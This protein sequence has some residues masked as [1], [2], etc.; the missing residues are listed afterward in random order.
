MLFF[1]QKI[2]FVENLIKMKRIFIAIMLVSVFLTSCKENGKSNETKEN[3]ANESKVELQE[4]E[5]KETN[6]AICLLEKLSIRETPDAKGKWVTSM[7]LGEKITLLGEETTDDKTKKLYYKVKLTDGKEGW[8]R[9]SFLAVNG[10][11]GTFL[12]GATVYKRPDLLT[13]T[14]KKYSVMD[15]IGTLE[16]QGEWIKVKGKRTD[17]EY[18]EEGWIKSSNISNNTVDIATAKY[19]FLANQAPTITERI[20]ALQEI[21]DNSDLSSSV[22]I[23]KIKSKIE[24]YKS[25]NTLVDLQEAKAENEDSK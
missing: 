21:I 17:G 22:F 16:N 25:K 24:D 7:S 13:K 3:I 11:V 9:A 23:E 4:K 5:T 10:E 14:D 15:I 20:E 6:S 19:A 12:E 1:F 2:I 18:I 8:T